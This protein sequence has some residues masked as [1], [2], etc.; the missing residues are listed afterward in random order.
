MFRVRFLLFFLC[1]R[2]LCCLLMSGCLYRIYGVG[3]SL[4]FFIMLQIICGVCLA[5]M[6]FSCFICANWYFILFLWDFDLGFVI[7]SIHI[8][9]T[10]L[11]YFLLYVHIFKCIIL[12]I[13][14]DTHLLV[15]FV[16][17]VLFMFIIVIAF[18]G[19]VLPCTMMSYWGLTV[20]N[21]LA[22]VPVI[23]QWLCY[24]IW[25]S[26]FINDFTLLKLHVLHV[27]LP[28]VLIMVLFLHL[29][30]LHYFMSSDAFCDR[31]AFYC[32][33]LCF[34]MW[35]YLRDM[36]LAFFILFCVMY[37]I[38]INWYFVFHEESWVIVD[39]LKTSDK[40]LPEWFFL[41]LGFLK[42]VPD[43][44]MGL[45]LMVV[46]LFALFMFILNCI[47]WFVYCRS[48][49]LWL[50]YSLILFYSIWM[51]GFL[52]LY[53]VLAYPIWMELQYWVLLLFL[54]VVCRLD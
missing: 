10:S 27:L 35:F 46:L 51:S 39:T 23:G 12:V 41:F 53:V 49:L 21:I 43:K 48:S 7:R 54:L 33:R 32:E 40:I 16:G 50:T 26:E 3:F 31:F 5:W 36:F 4:G 17:F 9:F 15:W 20:S 22:T 34:C 52:A 30:C 37:V 45:F 2:N 25:G 1:F 44:F 18:I 42:A 29:F 14:F 38:F 47:L 19:Y 11:L 13:L 6:F 24:W 28:F 8:C